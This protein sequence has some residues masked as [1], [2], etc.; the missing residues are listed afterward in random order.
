M[1]VGVSSHEKAARKRDLGMDLRVAANEL[2][3]ASK[4]DRSRDLGVDREPSCGI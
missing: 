2:Q 4:R 1:W 3:A